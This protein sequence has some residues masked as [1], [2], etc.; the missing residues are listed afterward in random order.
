MRSAPRRPWPT[1]LS[2]LFRWSEARPP[3]GS[4][5]VTWARFPPQ[6][7][8]LGCERPLRATRTRISTRIRL[9]K[10][11]LPI[12]CLQAHLFSHRDFRQALAARL[13][14]LPLPVGPVFARK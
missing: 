4:P 8:I 10:I 13:P 9:L 7:Q 3:G 1:C 2:I 14:A 11:R 6:R 5:A 12:V